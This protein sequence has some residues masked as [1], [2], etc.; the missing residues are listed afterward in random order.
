MIRY[1]SPSTYK[2]DQYLRRRR[3]SAP[4]HAYLNVFSLQH[5]KFQ[6]DL[7]AFDACRMESP[8]ADILHLHRFLKRE[9]F[10]VTGWNLKIIFFF[11]SAS[12]NTVGT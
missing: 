8:Y 11:F 6:T 4:V 3:S 2:I 12:P 1:K 10:I 7:Y 5:I 9:W